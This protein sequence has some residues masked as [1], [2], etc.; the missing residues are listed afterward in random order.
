MIRHLGEKDGFPF[1]GSLRFARS[2][3]WNYFK[4]IVLA[5]R[6]FLIPKRT[7]KQAR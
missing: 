3:K 5:L 1:F 7:E 4:L 2:S 6:G